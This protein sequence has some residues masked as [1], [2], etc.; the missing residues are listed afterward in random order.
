MVPRE[1]ITLKRGKRYEVCRSY[2]PQ[3][4]DLRLRG[5]RAFL[6]GRCGLRRPDRIRGLPRGRPAVSRDHDGGAGFR[7]QA[8]HARLLRRAR[9]PGG[10]LQHLLRLEGIAARR[11]VGG[12]MRGT[13]GALCQRASRAEADHRHGLDPERLRA[14][15]AG[16]DEKRTGPAVPEYA[17]L[18][19]G[20]GRTYQLGE[21]RRHQGVQAGGIPGR[22]SGNARFLGPQGRSWRADGLP[23]GGAFRL[24]LFL[25]H[26]EPAGAVCQ[27]LPGAAGYVFFLWD[28][29]LHRPDHDRS[30]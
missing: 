13:D 2:S 6:R 4:R 23:A 24:C 11:Q 27:I 21:Q 8:H 19:P 12:G 18:P 1:T 3:H 26:Q 30:R 29:R 14:R 25:L 5:G 10:G 22:E 16:A 15:R 28:H 9:P 20:R 7:R 17:G